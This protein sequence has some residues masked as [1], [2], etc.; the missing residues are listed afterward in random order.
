LKGHSAGIS[1]VSISQSGLFVSSGKDGVLKLWNLETGFCLASNKSHE[2]D[3]NDAKF[4]SN[5]KHIISV[6]DDYQVKL[7]D[8]QTYI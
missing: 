3:V 1:S 2:G 7:W 5:G 8:I 4:S 6:S